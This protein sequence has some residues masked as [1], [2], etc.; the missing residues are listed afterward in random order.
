MAKSIP[1]VKIGNETYEIKDAKSRNDISELNIKASESLVKSP[2]FSFWIT[3]TI[4]AT[5]GANTTS[6][7]RIRTRYTLPENIISVAPQN[8]YAV[9]LYAYNGDEFVGVW[10]GEAFTKGSTNITWFDDEI[11][12]KK[13]G[14]YQY[15]IVTHNAS[16]TEITAEDCVNLVFTRSLVPELIDNS[17]RAKVTQTIDH[18]VT[19]GVTFTALTD[20]TIQAY[21]IPA[22]A[23]TFVFL[24]GQNATKITTSPYD[25]TLDAGVYDVHFESTGPID[26][27]LLYYTES[28]FATSN[29]YRLR[30]GINV[31]PNDVMVGLYFTTSQDYGTEENP[32]VISFSAK[33]IM[34][35][36][37]IA[38]HICEDHEGRITSA[39]DAIV[40]SLAL[41]YDRA[42][43]LSPTE[44]NPIDLDDFTTPGNYRFNSS[45]VMQYVTHKP[46]TM[47]G[48][49]IVFTTNGSTTIGQIYISNLSAGFRYNIRSKNGST[50]DWTDWMVI[51][52]PAV[53]NMVNTKADIIHDTVMNQGITSITNGAN[54]VP[55]DGLV[56]G[57][58]PVQD[59]HGQDSP[60]PGGGGKNKWGNGDLS[61]DDSRQYISLPVNLPAGTYTMSGVATTN[62]TEGNASRFN[63]RTTS[64]VVCNLPANSGSRSSVTFTLATDCTE[65]YWYGG[66][67]TSVKYTS[68]ITDVQIELGSQATA[69]APYANLCPITGWDEVKVV[70]TGKNLF[71]KSD[72]N[73]ILVATVQATEIAS[74]TNGR[75]VFVRCKPNTTYTISKT[76]G[77]RFSIAY[78]KELPAVGV[79]I[80][81]RVISNA[82][83]SLTITTGGDAKYLV[84]YVYLSGTDT[85]TEQ[86]MLGSVQI[87][88]GS[89]VSAY[90]AYDG[91]T[92]SVSFPSPV[93]SGEIDWVGKKVKEGMKKKTFTS[94][95]S[96]LAFGTSPD[97]YFI[98]LDDSKQDDSVVPYCDSYKCA[99]AG[100]GGSQ[101]NNCEMWMQGNPT[102]PRL[103]VKNT[104]FTTVQECKS[105]MAGVSVIYELATPTE[106]PLSDVQQISTLKGVNNLWSDTGKIISLSYPCDTKMYMDETAESVLP[107]VTSADNG[108]VLRVVNGKWSA[109]SL[110][111]ANGVS[112]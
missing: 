107:A 90:S 48:R 54:G 23:R 18:V 59:L 109:V 32:S 82:A 17:E 40:N 73:S 81:G 30:N 57:I 50:N 53:Y 41:N 44:A 47:G 64:P 100:G 63:F 68:V 80:Y 2:I 31:F 3:G 85:I 78:T 88:L 103:Y 60:Y 19:N 8:G 43:T 111:S 79:S 26:E 108:K 87:E 94:N 36:D 83:S 95:D 89:T 70:R 67:S 34:P 28:T 96:W 46:S 84:A 92:Y 4:N 33:R 13:F 61:K 62:D 11:Y 25:K 42:T 24:N 98:L 37:I 75:T 66:S 65:V 52:D 22:N 35:N 91:K 29:R 39:E 20:D 51:N 74:S 101:H 69:F 45:S 14:D 27:L 55:I 6:S 112:F 86:K 105:G 58:E 72:G 15:R 16:S 9:A 71:N 7:T 21:G 99:E 104:A 97:T 56:V 1:Q 49:F 93:Y 77:V 10:T 38:R 76:A 110:P 12:F 102:Y 5:T 106:I